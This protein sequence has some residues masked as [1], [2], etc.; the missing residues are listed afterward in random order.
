MKVVEIFRAST[1]SESGQGGNDWMF[2]CDATDREWRV[3]V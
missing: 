1:P 2:D 3:A